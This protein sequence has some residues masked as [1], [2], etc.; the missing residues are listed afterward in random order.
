M[1][2]VSNPNNVGLNDDQLRQLKRILEEHD[3]IS[4]ERQNQKAAYTLSPD[5]V[6]LPSKGYVCHPTTVEIDLDQDGVPRAMCKVCSKA[7]S[8]L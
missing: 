6:K 4:L 8:V 2:R 3:I 7:W 1:D 5:T